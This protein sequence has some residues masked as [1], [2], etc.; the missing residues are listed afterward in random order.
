V[1]LAKPCDACMNALYE[2][3][4][5]SVIWT[6]GPGLFGGARLTGSMMN[7]EAAAS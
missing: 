1:A 6:A 4:I 7:I 3:G 2:S 5:T